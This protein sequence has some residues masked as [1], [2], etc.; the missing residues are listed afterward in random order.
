MSYTFETKLYNNEESSLMWN[1]QIAIPGDIAAEL[2]KPDKRVICAINGSDSYHCALNSDGAG[3]YYVLVNKERRKKLNLQTG[4]TVK[5]VLEKD[6][7]EYGMAVPECFTE[8]CYQ[9]P[10][11]DKLFHELTKG[12]Q[13]SL[14]HVMGKPKSEAK[15]LEKA[16][17]IFEYL[18][19]V[20]GQLDFKELNEAF[21]NSRFKL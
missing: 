20:N 10:E 11:G 12:R 18:K 14:L 15:Q 3:G 6:T 8:L 7:S 2:L 21:K 13:R 1:H 17:I 9:D 19:S 5:V 16:L 4:D